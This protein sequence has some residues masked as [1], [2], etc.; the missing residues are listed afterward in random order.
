MN[1]LKH[2]PAG[3]VVTPLLFVGAALLVELVDELVDG[4]SGAA[5]PFLRHDF[6]LSYVQVGLLLTVPA[7]LANLIE[8]VFG[9]LADAGRRRTI[10]LAGGVCFALSLGLT[11]AATG[12]WSLLASFMLFYP[13]SGAFVSLTQ[14]AWMDADPTRRE[15]NMTRWSLAGSVGNVVGPLLVSLSLTLGLGWR[16]VYGLLAVAALLALGLLW[17]GRS[18]SVTG[19]PDDSEEGA[20]FLDSLRGLLGQLRRA[21]VWDAMLLL[22]GS[23]LMLDIFRTFVAL[24]FMDAAGASPAQ[25]GLAVAV[26]TG[27][28]LLGDALVIPLLERVTG[29]AFVRWSALLVA[30]LFAAF[31]LA[32]PVWAKLTLLGLIGLFTSGWYAVLHARLYSLLPERSG[33]VMA[34]SSLAGLLAAGIPT[35]LGV[36][37]DR[38]GVQNALW[39]LLLG[40]LLLIWRLPG[41]PWRRAPEP[42]LA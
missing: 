31:L 8:P 14:A 40:P 13:A 32:P 3:P 23:N 42:P 18:L 36:L 38:Y 30:V 34:L 9:L 26:L 41:T 19:Q 39:L 7:V 1:N 37:A 4:A 15:Q 11:A 22:E 12:F 27:V 29:V 17:P 6:G 20:G 16:P 24:Y 10:V 33:A 35:M 5:W 2:R 25:A 21:E 28:G